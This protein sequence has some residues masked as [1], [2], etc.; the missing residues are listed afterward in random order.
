MSGVFT[1]DWTEWSMCCSQCVLAEIQQTQTRNN[2]HNHT[3]VMSAQACA[4]NNNTLVFLYVVLYFEQKECLMEVKVS[5]CLRMY[6]SDIVFA[7]FAPKKRFYLLKDDMFKGPFHWN[8]TRGF[9]FMLG[10]ADLNLFDI[11]VNFNLHGSTPPLQL[12]WAFQE[13]AH[14]QNSIARFFMC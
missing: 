7:D 5:L 3:F 8:I 14:D 10:K 13:C 2:H 6:Y 1:S 9:S 12:Q 4:A 11:K